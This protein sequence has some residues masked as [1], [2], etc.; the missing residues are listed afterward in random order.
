MNFDWN[1]ETIKW[2]E[3]ANE[4]T[5]FFK[6]IADLISPKL[7][8]YSTF[9]DIGCGLGLIDIELSNSIQSITCIDINENA[10][11]SLNKN[12]NDKKIK[13]IETILADYKKINKSWD[14]IHMSFFRGSKIEEFLPYCKKLFAIV[15]KND[16]TNLKKH[17]TFNKITCSDVEKELKDKNI[18]YSLTEVSFE[19]GQPLTS[20]EDAKKYIRSFAPR[21]SEDELD[22]YLTDN[23]TKT[24]VGRYPYYFPKLK[25]IGVFEIKGDIA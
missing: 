17:R 7:K 19:F 16:N 23:L 4:Y 18:E 1:P 20:I 22:R 2:Y 21:I 5:G 8:G 10:L 3:D 24:N 6:N 11:K 14:V 13:N 12:I 9:S 15:N 25:P